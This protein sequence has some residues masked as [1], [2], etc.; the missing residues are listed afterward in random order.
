VKH[1]YA[2]SANQLHFA[3]ADL[4]RGLRQ[5]MRLQFDITSEATRLRAEKSR[6]VEAQAHLKPPSLTCYAG[7]IERAIRVFQQRR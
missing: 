3:C 2:F 4:A 6:F 1:M 5:P 7:D